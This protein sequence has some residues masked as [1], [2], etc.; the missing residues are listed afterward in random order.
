M[1]IVASPNV[2]NILRDAGID[3]K[4]SVVVRKLQAE[5]QL[6]AK[7]RDTLVQRGVKVCG[8]GITGER[9]EWA[10]DVLAYAFR[11]SSGK[12]GEFIKAIDHVHQC[13][14]AQ[15]KGMDIS[16]KNGRDQTLHMSIKLAMVAQKAPQVKFLDWGIASMFSRFLRAYNPAQPEIEFEP[17]CI[18]LAAKLAMRDQSFLTKRGGID[19]KA[20]KDAIKTIFGDVVE[21]ETVAPAET[22]SADSDENVAAGEPSVTSEE[23]IAAWFANADETALDTLG[24]LMGEKSGIIAKHWLT[25]LH[26]Y[27]N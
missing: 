8:W 4:E 3:S 20:V 26:K 16:D 6:L 22:T 27:T 12:K 21:D 23:A 7:E 15:S 14:N 24:K 9:I 5:D 25:N 1:S 2:K 18:A 11:V 17:E 10:S 19:K 13:V